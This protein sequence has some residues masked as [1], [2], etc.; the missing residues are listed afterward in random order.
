MLR[1]VIKFLA[2]ISLL[3]LF[4]ACDKSEPKVLDP[5]DDYVTK[6]VE[7][8]SGKSIV[9]DTKALMGTVDK[10]LL[11]KGC[12]TKFD[13]KWLADKKEMEVSLLNFSVGNMP[14][15]INFRINAPFEELNIWDKDT[16][17]EK[18]W[19]KFQSNNGW[20][21]ADPKPGEPEPEKFD[22]PSTIEGFVNPLTEEIQFVINYNMMNVKSFCFRQK[23]DFGRTKNYE[24]EFKQYE[25]DLKAYKK[26]HGID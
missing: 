22:T 10:T 1:T 7:M 2:V 18:G 5:K 3:G 6:S 9:L 21:M 12:P 11:P 26:A 19:L 14:L 23:I 20:L 17:P 15:S 13:F 16:Y 25:A 8:L 24:Q 4:T